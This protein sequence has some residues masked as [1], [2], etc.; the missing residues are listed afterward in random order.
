MQLDGI[1]LD[2]ISSDLPDVGYYQQLRDYVHA[3]ERGR[4][5]EPWPTGDPGFERRLVRHVMDYATA[6]D[7]LVPNPW[8]ALATYWDAELE[9]LRVP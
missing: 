7:V 6:A 9:L 5:R 8:D 4:H 1:F 2:E 3:N